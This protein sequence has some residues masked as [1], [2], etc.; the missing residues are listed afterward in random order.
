MVRGIRWFSRSAQ[1]RVLH[2]SN[3]VPVEVE[4]HPGEGRPE[5]INTDEVIPRNEPS[6]LEFD[7]SRSRLL[8]SDAALVPMSGP[9]PNSDDVE[10]LSGMMFHRLV[11]CL[12]KCVTK[13]KLARF[14]FN[15]CYPPQT[16]WG[17]SVDLSENRLGRP[18]DSSL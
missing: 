10:R 2:G 11:C 14:R 5:E 13:E 12:K 18:R 16:L 9:I 17:Q 3:K 6:S 7:R 4:R 8:L 15:R 1:D